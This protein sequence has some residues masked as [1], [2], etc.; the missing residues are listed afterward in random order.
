MAK[1]AVAEGRS[2]REV[3]LEKDLVPAGRL[4]DVLDVRGMTEPG[5][6]GREA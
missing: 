2:V 4:D 5:I 1:Q 6:P 3:L